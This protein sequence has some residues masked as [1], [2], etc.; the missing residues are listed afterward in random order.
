MV[1]IKMA[2][3]PDII[4]FLMLSFPSFDLCPSR[5]SSVLQSV[6][7]VARFD[8]VVLMCQP[9]QQRSSHLGFAKH[10]RPSENGGW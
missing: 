10:A 1:R 5:Q 7:L 9:I 6:G 8:D 4:F 3:R 2:H